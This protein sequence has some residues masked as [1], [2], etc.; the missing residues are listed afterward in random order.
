[1][2]TF[3]YDSDYDNGNEGARSRN[4]RSEAL[5]CSREIAADAGRL[6]RFAPP[7]ANRIDIEIGTGITIKSNPNLDPRAEAGARDT[8]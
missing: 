1:V 5:A 4:F 7:S 2:R 6:M 3:D 8:P